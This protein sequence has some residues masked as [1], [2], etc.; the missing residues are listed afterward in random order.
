MLALDLATTTGWAY[1]AP[2]SIPQF[3]SLSFGK[4][5]S[6]RAV[7]Y[8]AFRD[9]LEAKWNV[10]D[11]Q[12]DVIVFES[13]AVP[14]I[15]AGRTRIETIKLLVGLTEH[16]EE[17]CHRKVE[18]R[19]ARVADVRV[20]FIGANMKSALAKQKTFDQCRMIGWDVQT[21]D[22]AD[23]CA[24]WDYQCAWLNPKLAAYSTPLFRDR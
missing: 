10:R 13:S 23:A 22:E 12:P 6:S 15:M 16:L 2:G 18:L 14:S 7:I 21:A 24:L 19:E 20:H 3:G 9:W 4:R 1:G 17:W 5:D 11:H 8:R